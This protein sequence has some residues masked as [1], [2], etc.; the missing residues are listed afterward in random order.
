MATKLIFRNKDSLSFAVDTLNQGASSTKLDDVNKCKEIL[1]TIDLNQDV[2]GFIF[3]HVA[4]FRGYTNLIKAILDLQDED[5]NLNT[6]SNGMTPLHFAAYLGHK[7]IA[8]LLIDSQK[9]NVNAKNK[10]GDTALHLATLQ[11]HNDI[12]KLLIS[13][14]KVDCTLQNND[15]LTALDFAAIT[16]NIKG[17]NDISAKIAPVKTEEVCVANNITEYTLVG[18]SDLKQDFGSE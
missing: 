13:N 1:R 6:S 18:N 14:A 16:D 12:V 4:V 7:E 10:D 5:I 11:H 15:K 17:Y 3:L 8:S 9:V 2:E